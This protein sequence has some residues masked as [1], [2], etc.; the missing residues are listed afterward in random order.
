MRISDKEEKPQVFDTSDRRKKNAALHRQHRERMWQRYTRK[1]MEAFSAVEQLEMLLFGIV[2]RKNTNEIAHRLLQ[3]F[4]DLYHVCAAD[5][6]ALAQIEGIGV[7]TAL[8]LKFIYDIHR[9]LECQTIYAARTDHTQTVE[10][11]LISYLVQRFYGQD[12]EHLLVV[13]LDHNGKCMGDMFFGV[14]IG[15]A[16]EV[17]FQAINREVVLRG[18]HHIVVAHNHPGGRLFPSEE[19]LLFTQALSRELKHIGTELVA[20]YLISGKDY[21]KIDVNLR[22]YAGSLDVTLDASQV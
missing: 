7:R 18:C 20:H 22:T 2:P 8:Y 3:K 19:D 13:F 5:P 16:A 10:T 11:A 1:G 6:S 17:S 15:N 12:K 14:G 9:V 4:G 21:L